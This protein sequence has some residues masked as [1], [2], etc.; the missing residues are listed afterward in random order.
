MHVVLFLDLGSPPLNCTMTL[1]NS[2]NLS[3]SFL[4]GKNGPHMMIVT[5][6]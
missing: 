4:V 1:G 6:K 3:F 2:L 5:V